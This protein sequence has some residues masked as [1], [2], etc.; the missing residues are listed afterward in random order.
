MQHAW[1][2][3]NVNKVQVEKQNRRDHLEDNDVDG[4]CVS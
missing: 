4:T 3:R 2:M 1:D